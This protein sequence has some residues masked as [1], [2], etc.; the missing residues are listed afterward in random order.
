MA[1]IKFLVVVLLEALYFNPQIGEKLLR[2]GTIKVRPGDGLRSAIADESFAA[3]GKFVALGVSAEIVMIVQDQNF[4]ALPRLP[5]VKE[6]RSQAAD[7]AA[8]HD[9]VVEIGVLPGAGPALA[10]AQGVSHFPGAVVAA[11][12]AGF[13]RRVG[14]PLF[15][16]RLI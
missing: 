3:A 13:R 1:G 11:A 15:F 7:A 5:A 4:C 12:H 8:H 9:E 2:L 6:G 16:P 10:I 14:G